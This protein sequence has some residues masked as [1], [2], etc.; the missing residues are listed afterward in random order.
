MDYCDGVQFFQQVV[1]LFM[2]AK[3][4]NDITGDGSFDT[5]YASLI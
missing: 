5:P 3:Y 1:K 4:G 2:L